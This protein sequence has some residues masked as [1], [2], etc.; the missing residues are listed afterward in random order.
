[1]DLVSQAIPN[2]PQAR[3]AFS[4]THSDTESDPRWG[5]LGM[6]CETS[7]DLTTAA[8]PTNRDEMHL[9]SYIVP[10][11]PEQTGVMLRETRYDA[12][13]LLPRHSR[14]VFVV[15]GSSKTNSGFFPCVSTASDKC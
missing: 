9:V 8:L 12:L 14:P 3:I 13:S 4:I 10:A 6:A 1:M 11:W 15:H 2:Q 7:M 5:W